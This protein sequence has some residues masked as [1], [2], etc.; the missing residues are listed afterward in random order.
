VAF[1]R[2]FLVNNLCVE[3]VKVAFLEKMLRWDSVAPSLLNVTEL[4]EMEIRVPVEL[5]P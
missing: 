5:V 3:V 4:V 1:K 2:K